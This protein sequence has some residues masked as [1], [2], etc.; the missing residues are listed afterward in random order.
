MPQIKES[1]KC[2]PALQIKN[3]IAQVAF[4]IKLHKEDVSPETWNRY[5]CSLNNPIKCQNDHCNEN[6]SFFVTNNA[7]KNV[8][9]L[10]L[11]FVRENESAYIYFNRQLRSLFDDGIINPIAYKSIQLNQPVIP[12]PTKRVNP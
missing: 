2:I 4:N 6:V 8:K 10:T 1:V 5:P 11:L 9:I 7:R 3:Q 12:E